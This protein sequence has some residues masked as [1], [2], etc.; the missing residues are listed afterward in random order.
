MSTYSAK[1]G[2]DNI[3]FL[4]DDPLRVAALLDH[5]LSEKD[6]IAGGWDADT[7]VFDEAVWSHLRGLPED[8]D[9]CIDGHDQIWFEGDPYEVVHIGE[10]ESA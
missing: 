3:V 1:I 4:I 8:Y 10:G 6:T 2:A 9:G 5:V 7:I